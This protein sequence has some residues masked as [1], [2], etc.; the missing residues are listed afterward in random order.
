MGHT[1]YWDVRKDE[2]RTDLVDL[3]LVACVLGPSRPRDC[4]DV[5]L[6][7]TGTSPQLNSLDKDHPKHGETMLLT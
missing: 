3:P 1:H 6:T 4:S 5:R 2:R 7:A